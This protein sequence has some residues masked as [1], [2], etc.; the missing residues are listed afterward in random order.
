MKSRPVGLIRAAAPLFQNFCEMPLHIPAQNIPA[1]FRSD[2]K[3]Q[4]YDR[5]E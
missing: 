2:E 1:Y 3:G 4:E 5:V